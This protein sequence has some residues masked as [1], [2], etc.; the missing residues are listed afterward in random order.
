[1][2]TTQ[3]IETVTWDYEKPEAYG[4]LIVLHLILVGLKPEEAFSK[5]QN[6]TKYQHGVI[7]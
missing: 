3:E 5:K 7:S 4:N 2:N 1:M 6:K